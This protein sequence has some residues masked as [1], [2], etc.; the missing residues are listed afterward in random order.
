MRKYTTIFNSQK[1][2]RSYLKIVVPVC[3][4]G[5]DINDCSAIY[6]YNVYSQ[7]YDLVTTCSGAATWSQHLYDINI[8]IKNTGA[9]YKWINE[10]EVFLETL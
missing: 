1:D 8:F 5:E 7:E 10:D 6:K 9:E 3:H 4:G 2:I